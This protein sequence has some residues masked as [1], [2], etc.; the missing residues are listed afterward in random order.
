MSTNNNNLK[1]TSMATFGSAT[2]YKSTLVVVSVAS[3]GSALLTALWMQKRHQASVKRLKEQLTK[4][5]LEERRGRIRA[6][7]RLRDAMKQQRYYVGKD[8]RRSGGEVNDDHA[9]CDD[10]DDFTDY[11]KKATHHEDLKEADDDRFVVANE[12]IMVL[13]RIGTIVSPFTKRMGTPRQ[14]SLSPHSRGYVQLTSKICPTTCLM[15]LDQYSHAWII[16]EFHANTNTPGDQRQRTKVR[17]PRAG[18]IKVGQLATR[19]PHR[20]NAIGLSL[21]K[22]DGIDTEKNLL[23]IS[24]LDLV[25]GTPVYDIKPFVPSDTPGYHNPGDTLIVPSWVTQ[26]DTIRNVVFTLEAKEKLEELVHQGYLAP[27]Y[28]VENCGI[29]DG[30]M[31]ISEV[32]SQDP[33]PSKKRG[34]TTSTAEDPYKIIFCS[35]QIE[36]IVYDDSISVINVSH[37]DLK[38]AETAQGL[39]L[40]MTEFT[41]S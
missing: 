4:I 41:G 36:F 3:V 37:V 1:L 11:D 33:R 2:F 20:P 28:T 31:A 30:L 23:I 34:T 19:S 26:D 7:I 24:S 6:E 25:H 35:I 21:V 12:D 39:P 29:S 5:R 17:P 40:V 14:G 13:K 15:G 32:L 27:L 10:N 38:S 16:F 22:V 18:G 8:K 9:D